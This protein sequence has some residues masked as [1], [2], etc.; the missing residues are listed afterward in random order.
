[1]GP[2]WKAF[3]GTRHRN[4]QQH[5]TTMR[6]VTSRSPLKKVTATKTRSGHNDQ[7]SIRPLPQ[8][9]QLGLQQPINK[10]LLFVSL[11][12]DCY[13]LK[14]FKA[15]L[16]QYKTWLTHAPFALSFVI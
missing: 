5:G 8:V 16:I 13:H 1:V 2:W 14:Q 12:L 6:V 10:L 3:K 9:Y 4:N 7:N 11:P 15:L